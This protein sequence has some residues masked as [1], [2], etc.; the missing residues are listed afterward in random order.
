[1]PLAIAFRIE[2]FDTV[3][4]TQAEMR[5]RLQR[6]EEVD[7]LVVRAVA[8]TQGRGR[9]G[10]SFVSAAGGS[11][12]TLAVRDPEPPLLGR[13]GS[14]VA[15]AVGLAETFGA[16][17][18][19]LGIKWP[20]DLV[21]RGRKLGGILTEYLRGHLLVGVGVNV[22]NEA[23][24]GATA[25]RGWDPEGV[26]GAV[27]AGIQRGLD[28]WVED[29]DALPRRFRPF[30]VLA[31]G[32]VSVEAGGLLTTGVARGI[33]QDGCLLLAPSDAAAADGALTEAAAPVAVCSGSV[34]RSGPPPR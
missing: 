31:G 24:E 30:D 13:G 17:G 10:R 2:T 20:N 12:Q 25:L 14:A 21:Y 34:A 7:G 29:A 5:A 28:A 8:Q 23:P 15:V 19:R 1:M 16:Y 26:S 9:R 22:A 3:P 4:S 6:G 11:Y 33:D 18:L 27:L 32:V